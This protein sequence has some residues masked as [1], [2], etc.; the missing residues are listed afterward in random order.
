M[1]DYNLGH[2][3]LKKNLRKKYALKDD[4]KVEANQTKAPIQPPTYEFEKVQNEEK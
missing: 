4:K 1:T 3:N 2:L